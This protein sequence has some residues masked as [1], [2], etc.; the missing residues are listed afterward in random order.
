[1]TAA[2]VLMEGLVDYAGLFPPA[3]QDMRTAVESYAAYRAGPDHLA[4]GR[5]IVPIARLAEFE[6][7]ARSL[8]PRGQASDPWR[9]SVLVAD[10][11][12]AAGEQ[13]LKFNC[14]HWS[15]SEDGHAV[16]DSVELKA[17]TPEDIDNQNRDLP[18]FFQRYFEIPLG[19]DLHT[20][21]KAIARVG[22]RAKVRTGGVT[23]KAFPAAR[24]I[25]DFLVACHQEGVAFKA[26][27][28][29]HHPVRGSYRL[30]YEKNSDEGTMYGFLNL[31]VAAALV[32]QGAPESTALAAL[33]E[34]EAS[35][36]E[37]SGDS[38]IWRGHRIEAS[39]LRDVRTGFAIS[40]GSCSFREPVDEFAELISAR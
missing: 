25:V 11:V 12:R 26:T 13:M 18:R 32:S 31:F 29:L 14:H 38:I 39:K 24:D 33:E 22:A 15:G 36:F 28:G 40:F 8:M 3:S 35:A 27:A 7:S 30:T 19:G 23:S 34:S 10:D 16:I 4:L 21:I 5:F 37:I 9:L 20:L 6:E 1:M 17:V 2:G